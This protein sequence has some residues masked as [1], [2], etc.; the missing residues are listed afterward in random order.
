MTLVARAVL[1]CDSIHD[2]LMAERAVKAAKIWCDLVPAPRE[3]SSDCGMALS[4]QAADLEAACAAVAAESV[5]INAWY[6][7]VE[8]QYQPV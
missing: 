6:Q 8:G 3:L 5:R 4:V 2:V 7:Q 1:L